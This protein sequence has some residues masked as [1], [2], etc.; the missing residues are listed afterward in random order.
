MKNKTNHSAAA[1]VVEGV[2]SLS[3]ML[4]LILGFTQVFWVRLTILEQTALATQLQLGPQQ[5][6]L[7]FDVSTAAFSVLSGSTTPTQQQFMDTI[8]NHFLTIREDDSVLAGIMTYVSIDPDTGFAT[9]IGGD[10]GPTFYIYP[11][12]GAAEC[13]GSVLTGRLVGYARAYT[14]RLVAYRNPANSAQVPIGTKLYDITTGSNNYKGYI[15]YIPMTFF[16]ICKPKVNVIYT[17]VV[18]RIFALHPRRLLN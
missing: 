7:A 13:T 16:Y 18:G 10:V 1:V 2:L 9:A 4:F 14:Q 15:N 8:G 11:S 6:S 12:D 17:G 3:L 5:P